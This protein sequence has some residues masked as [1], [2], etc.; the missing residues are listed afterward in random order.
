MVMMMMMITYDDDDRSSFLNQGEICLC[1]SR[2]FVQR[3]VYEEFL[4]RFIKSVEKLKVGDT[5]KV[6]TRRGDETLSFEI[7]VAESQ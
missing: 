5:V 1:T 4:A 6:E 3:P 2:V 7:E